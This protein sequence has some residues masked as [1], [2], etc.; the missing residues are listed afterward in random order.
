MPQL[1]PLFNVQI[2]VGQLQS[3]TLANEYI[4]IV[5]SEGVLTILKAIFR[6]QH[7]NVD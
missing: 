1:K 3:L 7:A 4:F 2:Y 6:L 5:D